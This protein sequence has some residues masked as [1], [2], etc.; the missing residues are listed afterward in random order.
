MNITGGGLASNQAGVGVPPPPTSTLGRE[1]WS[2]ILTVGFKDGVGTGFDA[3]RGFGSLDPATFRYAGSDF[4]FGE[5]Q[6]DFGTLF[7][8]FVR[9]SSASGLFVLLDQDLHL[10]SKS[11]WLTSNDL[12]FRL[13][14]F[15][16][17][18]GAP[19]WTVGQKVAL[20][21]RNHWPSAP[22]GLAAEPG[23]GDVTL[24]WTE[25]GAGDVTLRWTAKHRLLVARP[26]DQTLRG[27]R[28]VVHVLDRRRTPG[29][30]SPPTGT[31]R[32]PTAG[33]TGART[34]RTSRG[35]GRP[36]R[37]SPWPASPGE[38]HPRPGPRR[39]GR[40]RRHGLHLRGAGS[41]TPGAAAIPRTGRARRRST[42][43]AP[44]RIS[45]RRPGTAMRRSRGRRRPRTGG[46]T[47][48]A[49]STGR[50]TTGGTTGSR[51]GP[52]SRAARPS[53]S[54]RPARPSPWTAST[55][56]RPTPSRCG[57]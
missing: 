19:T 52:T 24:R 20:S 15:N 8:K 32:A 35:A 55:T 38:G 39:R 28:G 13:P 31:G 17:R 4:E 27:A 21:L 43:R 18:S 25:P 53:S 6:S 51:T 49:S 5:V 33:T 12:H 40:A 30:P 46:A 54:A 42:C 41:E 34:G 44:R 56:A 14:N 1:V 29:T 7:V 57:R 23:A 22:R 48:P 37:P 47:S 50:A 16:W 36:P 11:F 3:G 10:G 9:P 45:P 26:C 2:G